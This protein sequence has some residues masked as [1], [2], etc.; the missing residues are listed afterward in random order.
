MM[1][2]SSEEGERLSFT[3]EE[4]GGQPPRRPRGCGSQET[5]GHGLC[6]TNSHTGQEL[7]AQSLKRPKAR[8]V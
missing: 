1:Q 8:E 4:D 7:S 5:R 2:A 6:Y 3:S